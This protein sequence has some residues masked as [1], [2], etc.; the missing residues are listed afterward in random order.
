MCEDRLPVGRSHCESQKGTQLVRYPAMTNPAHARNSTN[1][2]LGIFVLLVC[3]FICGGAA[4]AK[5]SDVDFPRP[6]EIKKAVDFWTR[7]YSEVDT[8]S[9]FVHDS[10]ALDII[11]EVY[12]LPSNASAKKQHRLIRKRIRHYE[13]MLKKIADTPDAQLS[14]E[15]RRVKRLWGPDV[16]AAKLRKAA[17]RIRFQRGQSDRMNKGLKRATTYEKRIRKILHDKGVPVQLAALPHVESSYN[18]RVRSKAGAAGLW[19]IMPATGR[20]YQRVNNVVDERLDPYKATTAA[21]Q[22]LKHNYSVLKSWPLAITAYNHGLSGVRRAVR[23][24]GTNDIGTIVRSYKGRRF[25]F[26]S[27]NFYAAFLAAYDVSSQRRMRIRENKKPHFPVVA[28]STYMPAAAIVE[29]LG[30]DKQQLKAHNPDLGAAVWS[31]EKHIPKGYELHIPTQL[32]DAQIKKRV[33]ELEKRSGQAKQV[34]DRFYR[35][36]RGDNLAGIAQRHDT[37]IRTL[38][39]MNNLRSRHRINAGQV[40]RIPS[41]ND[42]PVVVAVADTPAND[43]S[44]ASARIFPA[45]ATDKHVITKPAPVVAQ[46]V[47]IEAS[48]AMSNGTQNESLAELNVDISPN[49]DESVIEENE[50]VV[51]AQSDL[52]ADPA[53]YLVAEDGTIEVQVGET[54][55]HYAHWLGIPTQQLRALNG[56]HYGQ[57]VIVGRRLKLAF[58]AVDSVAFEQQRKAFHTDLQN[59]FFENHRIVDVKDH[60]LTNGDNLWELSTK[61]YQ[62]PLW[63]LRQYN[64]DV[65]LDTVLSLSSTLR[66]PLVLTSDDNAMTPPKPEPKAPQQLAGLKSK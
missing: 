25:K 46:T 10:R 66:V 13:Q 7:V 23:K 20:R 42:A 34:P 57:N 41:A 58:S 48:H 12:P 28:L 40:L 53:D 55:G 29:E 14:R 37:T 8:H 19:Q 51:V 22:L 31:G 11:Y 54:L 39:A 44:N 18:P 2:T 49:N 43:K 17:K 33:V 15:E 35:I 36:Q 38:M 56:M 32:K 5:T 30:I 3:A 64:P 65:A 24:T 59:R 21:A 60:A 52:A 6:P 50:T 16:S 45:V 1:T 62:I 61:T 27:R 47:E 26:A 63:L 4:L 9:G